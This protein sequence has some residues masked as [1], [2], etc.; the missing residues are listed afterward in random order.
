MSKEKVIPIIDIPYN[1]INPRVIVTG[2]P[3][4]AEKIATLCENVT[5]V[6]KAREYWTYNG[7]YKGV[8]VTI[9]SNG[10]GAAGALLCFEGLILGGAKVMIRVGTGRIQ[11]RRYAGHYGRS[12]RGKGDGAGRAAVLP[13]RIQY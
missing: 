5:V 11:G 7:T 1:S 9:A 10:C 6:S 3:Y 13:R 4:R 8:P 2:D 12:A